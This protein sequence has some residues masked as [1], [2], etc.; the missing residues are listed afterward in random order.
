MCQL[1]KPLKSFGRLLDNILYTGQQFLIGIHISR[2]VECQLK[3]TNVKG[4]KAQAKLQKMLKKFEILSTKTITEQSMSSH[5]QFGSVTE[6]V[7]HLN[8]KPVYEPYCHEVC[9]PNT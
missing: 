7:R 3:L 9:S 8:Q 2:P 5:T 1:L 6:F 4:D